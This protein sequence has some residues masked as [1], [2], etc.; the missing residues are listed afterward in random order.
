MKT[1]PDVLLLCIFVALVLAIIATI[2]SHKKIHNQ[3]RQKRRK[4]LIIIL[5]AFILFL[6]L[7]SIITGLVI[8][9]NWE[10]FVRFSKETFLVRGFIGQMI[11]LVVVFLYAYFRKDSKSEKKT[12]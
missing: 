6:L 10:D 4:R 1:F 11:L 5:C 12:N 7:T 8:C 3:P 2:I 9:S